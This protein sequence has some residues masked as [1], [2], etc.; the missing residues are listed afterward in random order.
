MKPIEKTIKELQEKGYSTLKGD[1][2]NDS[3]F[4]D[5]WPLVNVWFGVGR[6]SLYLDYEWRRDKYHFYFYKNKKEARE[7]RPKTLGSLDV[8]HVE[9]YLRKHMP[10]FPIARRVA[11][12]LDGKKEYYLTEDPD[13][14]D[15]VT[16]NENGFPYLVDWFMKKETMPPV[17]AEDD[18]KPMYIIGDYDK[19]VNKLKRM[20]YKYH[21]D[22]DDSVVFDDI[23]LNFV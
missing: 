20:G 1:G 2:Y 12:T 21:L 8:Y 19:V 17:Y 3:E 4:P 23:E 14:V 15:A 10:Y 9:K 11:R 6:R 22:D 18:E 16:D 5:V 13:I 7:N